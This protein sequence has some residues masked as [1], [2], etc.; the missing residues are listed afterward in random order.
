MAFSHRCTCLAQGLAK[1]LLGLEIQ[2]GDGGHDSFVDARVA[3]QVGA[4]QGWG[5][6]LSGVGAVIGL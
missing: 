6:W 1:D 3:M 5:R 4:T 2:G